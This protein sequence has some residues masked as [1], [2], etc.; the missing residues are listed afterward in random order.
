MSKNSVRVAPRQFRSQQTVDSILDTAATLFVDVGYENATTNAIAEK[1]GISIGTLYRYFPD[2]DAVLKALADRYYQQSNMLFQT[3]FVEDAKYLPLE[4][5]INRLIDPYLEMYRKYPVYAH[6]LL[7]ADVS[8][9]IAAVSCGMEAEMIGGI[10]NFYR[11]LASHLDERRAY[12]LAVVSK[13][14]VKMLLSLVLPSSD[15]QYQADVIAEVKQMLLR[16]LRPVFKNSEP[17]A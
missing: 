15:E 9:D 12:L 13:A 11:V 8:L 1:A 5:L 3:L 17:D 14:A 2:K 4:I 6:I 16:Y 10:A 7:G